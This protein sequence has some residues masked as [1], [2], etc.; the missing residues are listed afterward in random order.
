MR[1][2][3]SQTTKFLQS[4]ITYSTIWHSTQPTS[5]VNASAS[6]SVSFLIYLGKH[7][8]QLV[9]VGL[10]TVFYDF[11]AQFQ[12]ASVQELVGDVNLK[13]HVQDVQELAEY[14]PSGC[15]GVPWSPSTR[16]PR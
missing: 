4:N 8:V 7:N 9:D 1:P 14:Q 15:T 2:N 3:T 11:N 13:K 5:F 6:D 16:L 10:E 12:K